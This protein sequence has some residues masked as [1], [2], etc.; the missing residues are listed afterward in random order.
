VFKC[1][2]LTE[3]SI[4][5]ECELN[6]SQDDISLMIEHYFQQYSFLKKIEWLKGADIE[7][8]RFKWGDHDFSLSFECLGQSIWV[9]CPGPKSSALLANLYQEMD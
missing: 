2:D 5:F 3:T 6:W 4:I 7:A 9:E 1:K 8:V